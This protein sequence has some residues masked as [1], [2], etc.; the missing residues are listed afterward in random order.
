MDNALEDGGK[1]YAF[2]YETVVCRYAEYKTIRKERKAG[3]RVDGKAAIDAATAAYHFREHLP[4]P[5]H[6]TKTAIA[7]ICPDYLLLGDVVDAAKHKI[8]TRKQPPPQIISADSIR[9]QVVF[10][11]YEDEGGEYKDASKSIEITLK[12]GSRRE[13]FDVLTNVVNMWIDFFAGGGSFREGETVSARG[14]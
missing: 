8:L 6:R 12:D 9:E 11:G 5:L 10:T 1:L 2:F 4:N 3:T 14:S 7:A 13:L